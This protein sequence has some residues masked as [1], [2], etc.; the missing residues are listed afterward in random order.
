MMGTGREPAGREAEDPVN[1]HGDA[2]TWQTTLPTLGERW[3]C[4]DADEERKDQ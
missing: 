1:L 4:L 2:V 3:S